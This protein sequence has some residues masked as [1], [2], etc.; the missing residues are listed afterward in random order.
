MVLLVGLV[1][2]GSRLSSSRRRLARKGSLVA[3]GQMMMCPGLG[4]FLRFVLAMCCCPRGMPVA[5]LA[6]GSAARV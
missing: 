4:V 1:V 2:V 5:V 3:C 6:G